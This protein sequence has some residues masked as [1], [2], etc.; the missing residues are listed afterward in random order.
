[1]LKSVQA[2]DVTWTVHAGE[3]FLG[4]EYAPTTE[5]AL[6]KTVSKLGESTVWD[7]PAYTLKRITPEE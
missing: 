7:V 6:A 3:L 5:R 2:N 1:M 4:Y